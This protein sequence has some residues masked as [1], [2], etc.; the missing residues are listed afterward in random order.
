MK[1][2]ALLLLTCA[3]ATGLH[4]QKCLELNTVALMAK[5]QT[6][7]T[8]ASYFAECATEKNDHGQT[9]IVDY[10]QAEKDLDA[11]LQR[12]QMDFA[13]ASVGGG[14]GASSQADK[15]KAMAAAMQNMT[16]AQKQAYVMQMASQMQA[17]A[18]HPTATADNSQSVKL[19]MQAYAIAG[20]QLPPVINEFSAKYRDLLSAQK[21]EEDAIPQP[22]T[23]DC[24]G[25]DKTGLPSC[26]CVNDKEEAYWN[27]ILAIRDEFNGKRAALLQQYLPRIK[28]MVGAIDDIVV[29]LNY[30]DAISNPQ[31]KKMLL[32]AQS[33]AFGNAFVVPS[34]IIKDARHTG[35]DAFVNLKN[36]KDKV[37]NLSCAQ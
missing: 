24:P 28:G 12:T 32:G 5:M 10:G 1:K 21:A 29:K 23:S 27:K 20:T 15:A 35:A 34:S 7:G 22:H 31:Y 11:L 9:V 26:A 3:I 37:Y 16:D 33:S 14:A 19:V 36:S 6:P 8:G 30:G 25:V 17:N 2:T 18:M 13:R 4:A